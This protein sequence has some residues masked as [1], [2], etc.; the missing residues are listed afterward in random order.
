MCFFVRDTYRGLKCA[1]LWRSEDVLS[2][3]H[4]KG[5]F[6]FGSANAP[7]LR[8]PHNN[9]TWVCVCEDNLNALKE[10]SC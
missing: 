5:V 1:F 10:Q 2:G 6:K 7:Y 8:S 3:P 9:S 4:K